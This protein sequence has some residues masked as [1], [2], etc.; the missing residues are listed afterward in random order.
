M[1]MVALGFLSIHYFV[2]LGQGANT[3]NTWLL[4]QLKI[5]H[6]KYN[7]VIEL[8]HRRQENFLNHH[9]QSLFRYTFSCLVNSKRTGV[10]GGIAG[11]FHERNGGRNI[12]SEVRPFL[13]VSQLFPLKTIQ[14]QLRLRNEFRFFDGAT[15]DQNRL[16]LQGLFSYPL[17]QDLKTRLLFF[18]E[19]F[20]ICGSI[21]PLEWR[22]GLSI[23]RQLFKHWKLGVGY[24]Y[25][26]NENSEIRNIHV[27]QVSG[28]YEL[29]LN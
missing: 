29:L 6:K 1:K 28:S 14:F 13:Q 4:S 26:N 17:N 3:T 9:R 24:I 19:L 10:G 25:Q 27:I 21:K 23:Q 20:Y 15:E 7:H 22:G 16:R 5:D 2:C 8:G 18:N 11:F 12:E